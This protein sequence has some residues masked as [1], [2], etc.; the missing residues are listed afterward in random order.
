MKG[1]LIKAMIET[2]KNAKDYHDKA[3]EATDAEAK[4]M[5]KDLALGETVEFDKLRHLYHGKTHEDTHDYWLE[6]FNGEI[7]EI[8]KKINEIA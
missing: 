7:E 3:V 2:Y 1:F 4:R 5:L 8:R 6:Y